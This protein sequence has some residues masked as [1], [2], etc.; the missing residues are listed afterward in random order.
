MDRPGFEIDARVHHTDVGYHGSVELRALPKT[1]IGANGGQTSVTYDPNATFDGVN[2]QNQLNRDM[3]TAAATLRYKLTPLTSLTLS[4]AREQDRFTN[5]HLRD[6]DSTAVT[7]TVTFDPFALLKGSATFG[8][9]DFKP[10]SASLAPF[11]GSIANVDLSY[12][13]LGSTKFSLNLL[14][15]IQFSYDINNSYYLQ[16]G[17][18]FSITQQIFGPVDLVGRIG[19]QRLDYSSTLGA[20][21]PD[22]N[23]TDYVHIYGGGIGY[24]LG[25][26]MRIGFN[27]EDDKRTSAIDSRTYDNLKYGGSVTYGF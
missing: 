15:D 3:T 7:G 24:H 4:V 1:Y 26:T 16:T 20:H 10:L 14:R 19:I 9:R 18:T 27:V 2:L 23:R 12:V 13:L 22:P 5:D 21:I 11:S 17:G 25:P 6:A 8:W